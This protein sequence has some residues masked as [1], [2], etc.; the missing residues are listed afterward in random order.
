MHAEN[1]TSSGELLSLLFAANS[2][3]SLHPSMRGMNRQQATASVLVRCGICSLCSVKTHTQ[4]YL[5]EDSHTHE[6]S[7]RSHQQL[8]MQINGTMERVCSLGLPT[9]TCSQWHY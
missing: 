6:R 1:M 5:K 9:W 3:V 7:D 8:E 4:F 2:L